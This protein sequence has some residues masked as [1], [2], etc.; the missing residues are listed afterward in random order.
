MTGGFLNMLQIPKIISFIYYGK[1]EE[2]LLVLV[3][4]Q[5]ENFR[6]IGIEGLYR[7]VYSGISDC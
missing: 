4:L 7:P 2:R 5:R 3:Y 1:E 6:Q